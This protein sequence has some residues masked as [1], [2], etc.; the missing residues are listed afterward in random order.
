MS[1]GKAIFSF[2]ELVWGML[3]TSIL[4]ALL[5]V[6]AG[7]INI[8]KQWKKDAIERCQKVQTVEWCTGRAEL[9]KW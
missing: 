8:H 1:D 7:R 5:G 9:E 4:S 3:M 6:A 2:G